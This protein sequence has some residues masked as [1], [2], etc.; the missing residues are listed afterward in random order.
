MQPGVAANGDLLVS[1]SQ[2]SGLRRLTV[3]QGSGGWSIQERWTT[4]DIN[5]WFNDFVV[6]NGHVYGFDGSSLVCINLEDG[7]LKWKGKRYGYG[8]LVLLPDQEVLLVLSEKGELALA[9]AATDQFTELVTSPHS[10]A[11]HGITRY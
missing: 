2:S 6:H 11:R 7:K 5:P 8:Q 1:V 9:K 10:K 3:G 4:E